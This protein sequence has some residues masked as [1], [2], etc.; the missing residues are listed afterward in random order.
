M[1]DVV[2]LSLRKES[3]A[4]GYWDQQLLEDMFARK[5]HHESIGKLKQ[6]IVVIPTEYQDVNKVNKDLS[7]LDK[8]IVICTSDEENKFDLSKLEHKNMK[9]YATYPHETDADVTWL[10]I[11]YTP[12]SKTV[13]WLE[14]DIDIL[15]AGQVN[16]DS[17]QKM[18]REVSNIA[19][20]ELH[21]SKGFAQGLSR[22]S[23]I[24]KMRKAKV[25]PC[26]R[27]NISPDSFRMYEA[28]EHGALPI[29][30][31][32][33]FFE[34]LFTAPPFPIIDEPRQWEGYCRDAVTSFPSIQNDSSA[35]WHRYKDDLYKQFND[36][37][38]TV[39]I[40][41]SPIKSHPDT[42]ILDETIKS[43]RAHLDCRIVITFDGVREE[44]QDRKGDYELF[45]NN[46]LSSG[47]DRIYPIIFKEHEHQVGMLRAI[48]DNI[49]TP[50]M[51][52][53]EQ[54]T[55]LTSDREIEWDKIYDFIH[56]GHSDL[57]RLHFESKIPVEHERLMLGQPRRGFQK[58]LQ[59]S[60]RPHVAS[61]AY[62]R[63]ILNE[64]FSPKAKSF[65]EDKMHSVVQIAYEKDG[66]L[67]WYQHKLHIYHPDGDIKR[68]YHTD[69][70]AG[71][72]KFDDEQVF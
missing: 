17:R 38:V 41:V 24:E 44:Q 37:E 32:R 2:W 67:G 61:T 35:W 8:C 23:Y 15:F 9:L 70:R 13:G 22:E 5:T 11:G 14:K 66:P 19:T 55:P 10:P 33:E 71:E 63:R 46:V 21:I 60:Q 27:G 52:Y 39:V 28:L 56:D 50:L 16:H 31:N 57:V 48:I 40:P 6:A 68:S 47:Y 25:I 72:L 30:E 53:V 65:I 20:S 64:A 29:C 49:D 3:P 42:S 4:R 58:T 34:T 1:N 45:I 69:G 12:H 7:R 54:D 62:Y 59:W 43:I 26:P 18:V 51:M 36:D